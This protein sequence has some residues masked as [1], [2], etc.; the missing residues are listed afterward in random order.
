LD[1]SLKKYRLK[2]NYEWYQKT[3]RYQNL[4]FQKLDIIQT[5]ENSSEKTL[6][7]QSFYTS[8]FYLISDFKME[9]VVVRYN[10]YVSKGKGLLKVYNYYGAVDQFLNASKLIDNDTINCLIAEAYFK[11]NKFNESM[12]HARKSIGFNPLNDVAYYWIGSCE[13]ETKNYSKSIEN[14]NISIRFNDKNFKYWY[15]RGE[16]KEF[17]GDGEGAIKD[18]EQVLLIKPDDEITKI[19]LQR[20]KKH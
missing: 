1:Q 5:E 12:S 16:C 8:V 13:M 6:S 7:G 11:I 2:N 14:Y 15:F 18:Y 9:N 3:R 17:L 4:S 10:D 20:L 19:K